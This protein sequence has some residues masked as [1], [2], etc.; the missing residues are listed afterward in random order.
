M[1]MQRF[2]K[3]ISCFLLSIFLITACSPAADNMEYDIE[4]AFSD[5]VFCQIMEGKLFPIEVR[6]G[7][8]GEEGYHQYTSTDKDTIQK[9]IEAFRHLKLKEIVTDEQD[10]EH[11]MDAITDYIFYLE[12]GKEVLISM[13]HSAYVTK[14]DKQYVYEY[15]EELNELNQM[16]CEM[17][18][19]PQKAK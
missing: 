3:L 2:L 19:N 16:I 14:E 6:Y 9:Y 11:M 10:F 13:D 17:E 15:S 12:D 8:G 1:T 7:V 18:V 4:Q 5:P